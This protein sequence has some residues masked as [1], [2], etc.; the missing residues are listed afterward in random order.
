MT[1]DVFIC[2]ASEDKDALVRPLARALRIR[3]VD[4]WYDEFSM[5]VGDSL[6]QSI[7]RGLA[8]SRYGVVVLSPAFFD[9]PWPQWELDGLVTKMTADRRP[10]ILP[11]W[12][13]VGPADVQQYSLPLAGILAASSADGV[14]SVCDQLLKVLRPTP[15][16]LETAKA[17]LERHGW[18]APPVS[19]EFWLDAVGLQA[20]IESP[21]FRRAWLFPHPPVG[22][23][24][25][26]G[27]TIAWAALQNAW[28]W[29]AEER[30]ICQITP[31]EEVFAFIDEAPA[32][33]EAAAAHPEVVAN[34]APQL[35]IREFSGRFGPAFDKLL[36]TSRR[37]IARQPDSRY[38]GAKCEKAFALRAANFGGHQ[39]EDIAD[40]WTSG[41]GGDRSAQHFRDS[42]YLFWL[43]S[44][45]SL[46]LPPRIR[47]VL[48]I[49]VRDRATWSLDLGHR[50]LWM[51]GLSSEFYTPRRTAF[52]WTPA[53][54]RALEAT[55]R[56]SL[57]RL[58]V[59][60]D[61]KA[62]AARFI[63]LDVVGALDRLD[64]RRA[65]RRS[66]R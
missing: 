47:E 48:T 1:H 60:G 29:E 6:R 10:T 40:K 36:A 26:R 65:R 55:A 34:Y 52:R 35:L 17:E 19:D 64:L 2:H 50:D 4:V 7:D 3:N 37:R 51:G 62:M 28:N 41:D 33:A 13:G 14:A 39:P 61:P 42:D 24:F 11:V 57:A 21:G 27:H 12:H 44:D 49:G 66:A 18:D 63:D 16:P 38:P 58:R 5:R 31:P 32:L 45:A 59:D 53:R 20:D 8:G 9:K 23:A 43:L 54:V 25:D 56:G 22:A 30:N 15:S 46:W